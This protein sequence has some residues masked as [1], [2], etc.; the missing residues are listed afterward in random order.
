MKSKGKAKYYIRT[1]QESLLDWNKFEEKVGDPMEISE[2]VY[3]LLRGSEGFRCSRRDR[4]SYFDQYSS[5]QIRM[6]K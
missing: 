2:E 6:V 4:W 5:L 1:R 3:E